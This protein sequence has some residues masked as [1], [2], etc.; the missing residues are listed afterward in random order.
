MSNI[1]DVLETKGTDVWTV[2]PNATVFEAVVRMVRAKIGALAVVDGEQLVGIVTERDYL[3]KVAVE[4]RTSR[5]TLVHEIMS[6]PVVCANRSDDLDR[7]LSLMTE[8]RIRHLPIVDG[9]RLVGLISMGDLVRRKLDDQHQE[10]GRLVE[11]IQTSG[12]FVA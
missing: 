7:C 9:T 11:Y 3:R 1:G 6:C 10:I 4:G 12:T 2:D 8:R 5:T